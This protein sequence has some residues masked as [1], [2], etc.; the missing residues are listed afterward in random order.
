M[1]TSQNGIFELLRRDKNILRERAF[2]NV[3]DAT[4]GG[5]HATFETIKTRNTAYFFYCFVRSIRMKSP[6]AS[7]YSERRSNAA[8]I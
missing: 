8:G 7:V 3:L 1:F 2:G 5:R 6:L 4:G